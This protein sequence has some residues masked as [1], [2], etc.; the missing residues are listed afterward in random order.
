[1]LWRKGRKRPPEEKPV[2]KPKKEYPLVV[3]PTGEGSLYQQAKDAWKVEEEER[4][5]EGLEAFES[6]KK[7]ALS[8]ISILFGKESQISYEFPKAWSPA[9]ILK[10]EEML[11]CYEK[12]WGLRLLGV[13]C[14][15][16]V[17]AVS[18]PIKEPWHLGIILSDLD[19]NF[20]NPIHLGHEIRFC[21]EEA[22]DEL[23]NWYVVLE[24][25][26]DNRRF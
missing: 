15:C 17:L 18:W 4:V 19:H 2:E 10:C 8:K 26:I 14:D 6:A 21:S 25:L 9:W 20:C 1:M 3:I 5:L 24:D 23:G 22:I 11:F 7:E 12:L 16:H 13:C